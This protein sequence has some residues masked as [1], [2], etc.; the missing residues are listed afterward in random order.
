MPNPPLPP[1]LTR[2]QRDGIGKYFDRQEALFALLEGDRHAPLDEA[3]IR[4]GRAALAAGW[5]LLA[6]TGRRPLSPLPEPPLAAPLLPRDLFVALADCAIALRD[7]L[8]S[9]PGPL[10]ATPEIYPRRLRRR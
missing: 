7:E 10:P 1:P 5:R 9:R 4:R 3:L 6:G 2:R 8:M